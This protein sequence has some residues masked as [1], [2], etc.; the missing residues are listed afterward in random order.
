MQQMK[1]F[2]RAVVLGCLLAGTAWAE[3]ITMGDL[4]ADFDPASGR[5]TFARGGKVFVSAAYAEPG[6]VGC[7]V[8]KLSAKQTFGPG[9]M[10]K[11]G[12]G[13]DRVLVR[14]GSPFVYIRR[15]PRQAPNVPE[16]KQAKLYTAKGYKEINAMVKNRIEVLS[17]ALE[18]GAAP[19]KI[20]VTGANGL[21]TPQNNA[22]QLVVTG[23]ADMETGAGIVAGL[24]RIDAVCGTALTK[25]EQGKVVLTLRNEYGSAIPPKLEP[26]GGD[27]WALGAFDDVRVGLENYAT[28]FAR[29]NHWKP[30]PAPVAY[31]SWYS[32]GHG[33]ALSEKYAVELAVFLSKTFKDYGYGA[34]QIDDGWQSGILMGPAKDFS[35]FNPKGPYPNGMKPVADKI[36]ELGLTPGLWYLPF[37]I[38]C[39][40][41][42]LAHLVPL[43]VKT[44][45][46]EPF[47]A[48]WSGSA[49]DMTIPE[50]REYVAGFIRQ[51]VKDWGFGY[52]KLD[53]LH[54]ALA[55]D[56]TSPSRGFAEDLYSDVVF[57]D[58]TMS[59]MQAARA[60]FK[61]VREAAG[62][63]TFILG[64]SATQ[65]ARSL[66]MSMGFVDAM[67]VGIDSEA[68][69][70]L[71]LQGMQAAGALYFFNGRVWWNDPDCIALRSKWT[72]NEIQCFA[73]WI[74]LTGMLNTQCDWA[75][76]YPPERV[77]LLKRTMPSHQLTSV[78][79]VDYLENDPAR[80]WVLTYEVSG[81][82]HEVVGLFNW[83]DMEQELGASAAKLGIKPEAR[84]AGYEFWS[85]TALPSFS[86]EL[87]QTV[88][89]RTGRII[90]V[91]EIGDEPAVLSTSRHVTQGAVDLLEEK[92]DKRKQRLTGAS[93]LVA[94]D[95]YEMRV[96]TGSR[97][98]KAITADVSKA[99]KKAGVTV[100]YTQEAGL[101]RVKIFSPNNETVRW[102]LG[103]SNPE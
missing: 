91:R 54:I 23:V 46:G 76:N 58:K 98:L 21:H 27:W 3:T 53:G 6:R 78:R 10:L 65:N 34:L 38:N 24:V 74:T 72:L 101:V 17:T 75:P 88:P 8:E 50:A 13:G 15:D 83:T 32:E 97:A 82:K 19:E 29:V 57:A 45:D 14:E 33:G 86:G 47:S 85:N 62:P 43:T 64:C 7:E 26:F 69:W 41:P 79:P 67:R 84:Y 40:D 9:M 89:A 99:D 16:L 2:G 56:Q 96:L 48:T 70:S 80:I 55:T 52:L 4:S 73:G 36:R 103:F 102:S 51:G 18:L 95:P 30:R 77:E 59:N 35:K 25:V 63:E 60:G 68:A 61:A 92:W 93:K 31:M 39:S 44:K 12:P 81:K 90:A 28:E 87:K 20:R 49:L 5:L 42:A 22:G 94:N 71:S 11:I 37:A 66:G 1:Q 100:S